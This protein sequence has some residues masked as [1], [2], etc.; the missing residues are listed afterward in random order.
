MHSSTIKTLGFTLAFTFSLFQTV[1][2]ADD[3]G[4]RPLF[5]GTNTA[6]WHLRY[7]QGHNSWTVENGILK[8][9][10]SGDV[11]GTDLVTD[12]KFWNFTVRFEYRVPQDSNSGFY[13]RGRHELQILGD[14]ESRTNS[15]SGNG[16]IYNFKAPDRFVSPPGDQWQTVEATMI[17]D[18]ITVVH[19]GL[20]T[21][22]NVACR[23]PTGSELDSKVDDPGSIFLQGDHGTVW[24]RRIEIRALD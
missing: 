18:R 2:A 1:A 16:A 13:L 20:L 15:P 3:D 9:T 4:F 12:E 24:F 21:H 10:V 11:H 23:Q 7:P 19:N 22:D 6:G 5:N 8:N 14:H 17:G